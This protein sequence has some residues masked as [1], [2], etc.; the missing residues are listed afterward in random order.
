MIFDWP[1]K[2]G[3]IPEQMNWGA[4]ART[5]S[6]ESILSGATQT[7]GTPGKR[8][9]VG[10]NLPASSYTDR[11]VRADVEGFLDRLGGREHR[12]RLWHM[13]RKGVNGYGYPQGTINQ[14]GVTSVAA[15]QFATSISMEN[16]GAYTTLEAG[17]F[18]SVNGQLIMNPAKATAS[19][20]GI[21]VLPLITRLRA[22]MVTGQPVTVVRPTATFVLS[23]NSW[24]SGYALGANQSMGVDFI[25]V[26]T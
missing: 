19:A 7:T 12:V 18:F 3:F 13:G 15:N 24:T 17:D 4:E 1:F 11:L 20:G 9:Q 22:S 16:C 25:E 2:Q 10:M 5:I 8:W 23:S 26:F 21:I 14:T 6:S